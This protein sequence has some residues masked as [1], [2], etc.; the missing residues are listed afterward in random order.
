MGGEFEFSCFPQNFLSKKEV[1]SLF[2]EAS[3]EVK[4]IEEKFTDFKP[5]YFNRIND[6]AGKKPVEVDEETL[7]LVNESNKISTLSAGVFDISFASIGH[8]WR[9]SKDEGEPLAKEIIKDRLKYINY[10]LIEINE[11]KKT[12]Y[13]P[14]SEMKI[15]LGG[16]G[17]GYAVDQVYGLFVKRGLYNFYINGAGDIRVHSRPDAPRK[18]RVGIRNPL[19]KDAS[20][21]VGVIQMHSGAVASSGGY[22]HNVNGD[23]KNHHILNPFTGFSEGNVI[24]STVL[25]ETALIA[26]T[27]A[28]I[29]MNLE[30]AAAIDYLNQQELIGLVFSFE[31]KSY[32]SKMALEHFG[33]PLEDTSKK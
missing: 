4:R 1:Y 5:S 28:T 9:A 23:T 32:L 2:D 27:T 10:K 25:A 6:E 20:K 12:I 17:K 30:V 19:S 14:F 11:K 8:L 7:F 24:A 22:V 21:S 3:L 26:D 29:L 31:G 15:G 18:W 33:N 16:I 13:L